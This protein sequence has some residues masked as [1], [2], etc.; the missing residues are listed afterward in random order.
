MKYGD[1]VSDRS[2]AFDLDHIEKRLHSGLI[3][4]EDAHVIDF[5][6][7]TYQWFWYVSKI[8]GIPPFADARSGKNRLFYTCFSP[9]FALKPGP[10]RPAHELAGAKDESC[11]K[12]FAAE[13]CR[14]T[15]GKSCG[16]LS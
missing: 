1:L 3:R 8:A 15:R 5:Y 14:K 10:E 6:R 13:R 9:S 16:S 12:S 7:E 4:L 2:G 11:C